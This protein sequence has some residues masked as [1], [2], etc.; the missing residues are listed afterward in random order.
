MDTVKISMN[1][2]A[3]T[4]TIQPYGAPPTP[5]PWTLILAGVGAAAAVGI[6]VY[7]ATRKR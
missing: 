3:K 4:F 6:I 7:V 5:I 2:E 1:S